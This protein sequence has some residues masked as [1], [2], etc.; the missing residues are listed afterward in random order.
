MVKSIIK[1]VLEIK[2]ETL[3]VNYGAFEHEGLE[4]M[5]NSDTQSNGN[6]KA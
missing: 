3:N 5:R 6:S 4:R 1:K 2:S